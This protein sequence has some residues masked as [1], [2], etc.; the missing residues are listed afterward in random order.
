MTQY[1]TKNN[2]ILLP[3]EVKKR[4]LDGK[5]LIA[6]HLVSAGFPVIIGDRGG[7]SRELKLLYNCIYIAKSL[8]I[9]LL[10]TFKDIKKN[11]GK[12]FVLFEEGGLV[13]NKKYKFEEIKSF[14]PE[15]MLTF[16]D[17]I[18][19]YGVSYQKLLID[20]VKTLNL[21]NTFVSGN[22]R[23]DLH[24]PKYKEYFKDKVLAL[25]NKYGKY[26]LINGNFCLG[27]NFMG[28]EYIRNEL[29]NIKDWSKELVGK[30]LERVDENKKEL[31][32]F[33]NATKKI[34]EIFTEYAIIV[35]PHPGEKLDIYVKKLGD[36]K[37]IYVTNEDIATPWILGSEIVIHKDCTTAVESFF[38]GKPIISYL[39]FKNN[40]DISWLPA[41]ISEKAHNESELINKIKEYLIYNKKFELSNEKK[42]V[43]SNEI[44]NTVDETSILITKKVKETIESF[45]IGGNNKIG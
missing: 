15:N 34:A 20:N 5:L 30:Y 43:L 44:I 16:V 18:F 21:I 40:Y 19:V 37:N 17:S 1:I 39:L 23:F 2:C 28:E 7:C 22:A 33:I 29:S 10:E 32:K 41:Y 27:N 36:I 8:S 26:I 14:Y 12:I 11:D 45:K 25:R 4:E 6:L 3:I 24:K 13:S 9:D 31:E 38:A 42:S 35:R